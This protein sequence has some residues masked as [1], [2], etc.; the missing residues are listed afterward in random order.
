MAHFDAFHFIRPLWLLGI[1]V[2]VVLMCWL[3]R[4][5]GRSTRWEAV[6]EAPLLAHLLIRGGK[7]N[8]WL[9]FALLSVWVLACVALAGPSWQQ[10]PQPSYTQQRPLV[11]LLDLSPSMTVQD[12]KPS[13]LARARFKVDDLLKLRTQG[14]TGLVV[15]GGSAH[16]MTPLSDDTQTLSAQL[17]ALSP[18]V[19]PVSGSNVEEG[20]ARALELLAQRGAGE[21][22]VLLLTDGVSP[23]AMSA[24]REQ[25]ANTAT[26]LSILAVGT[27]R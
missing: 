2:A 26:R 14:L 23:Q 20:L 19:M 13:R 12:I 21:G 1:V 8:T 9:Y 4:T 15:Y 11:I 27:A 18:S 16:I 3:W 17:P 5:R 25:L 7:S 10:L 22:D 6:V 24:L